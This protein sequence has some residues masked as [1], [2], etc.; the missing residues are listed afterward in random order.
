MDLL[1]RRIRALGRRRRAIR[2]V[3]AWFPALALGLGAAA[4]AVM[5]VRVAVPAGGGW[6]LPLAVGGLIAPL[7]VLPRALRRSDA[8]AQLAGELDLRAGAHGLVMALAEQPGDARAPDWSQRLDGALRTALLPALPWRLGQAPLLAAALLAGACCLPQVVVPIGLPPAVQ[9]WFHAAAERLGDLDQGGLIPPAAVPDLQ[10]R[11]AE[12]AAHA[13]EHGMDQPTWEGLDRVRADLDQATAASAQRLAQAMA[14]AEL[15]AR[16]AAAG[17]SAGADATHLAQALAQL[18]AQAPGLVPKLAAGAGAEELTA[19]LADA[20]KAGALSPEQADAVRQLGL[21]G[22]PGKAMTL[23]G[24]A[25]QRLAARISAE[26][27]KGRGKLGGAG[28]GVDEELDRLRADGR[29]EHGGVDQGPGHPPLTWDDPRRT[30]GGGVQSLPAGMQ[31]NP[32]GSVT[33]AEQVRDAEVDAQALQAAARAAARAF[34]PTAAEARRA[35]VSAR[36]RAAVA[37]YFKA[38]P[39][40]AAPATAPPAALPSHPP[41]PAAPVIP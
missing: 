39:A 16:P 36:H 10:Q 5:V 17:A 26:L 25:A 37:D 9:T 20:V 7:V 6:V 2:A 4:T 41:T 35:G 1:D 28:Q 8:R 12:L 15:Q 19:A 21:A 33:V 22:A 11:L 27:A 40:P 13:H 30:G 18:A 14:V 38:A 31:V 29:N 24:A 3:R 34:D 32:D 23:D